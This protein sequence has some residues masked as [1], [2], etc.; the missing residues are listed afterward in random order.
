[1]DEQLTEDNF[2]DLARKAGDALRRPA[3]VD[4]TAR[5]HRTRRR[6]QQTRTATGVA[7]V[8]AIVAIGAAALNRGAG[9]DPA[10]V[11]Q[12][13]VTTE[14]DTTVPT[15][16]PPTT[17][18]GATPVPTTAPDNVTP[19]STDGGPSTTAP[20][21]QVPLSDDARAWVAD[22]LADGYNEVTIQ[23]GEGTTARLLVAL[24]AD[25]DPTPRAAALLDDGTVIGDVE[26]LGTGLD[27]RLYGVGGRPALVQIGSEG[28]ANT[29]TQVWVADPD[30]RAW[31][32]TGDLGL[33]P[34][35]SAGYASLTIRV[36]DD[37]LIVANSQYDDDGNGG[38]L[39]SPDQ[40]GVV[41]GPDL[42]VTEMAPAPDGVTLTFTS[43]WGGRA[44]Q[45]YAP[46][47]EGGIN[48][49]I[50]YD[51]PWQYD[52]VA[53]EWSEIPIPDWADC[54][55]GGCGWVSVADIGAFLLEVPTSRGVVALVPDGTV[56]L[57]DPTA[58][59]WTRLDDPPFVLAMPTVEVVADQVIVGPWRSGIEEFGMIGVL[60]LASGTWTTQQIEIP[61]EIESRFDT[62]WIDVVWHFRVAG[63]RVMATPGSTSAPDLEDPIAVY[64]ADAR[65][66]SEPT[67]ADLTAWEAAAPTVTP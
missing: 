18:P 66:W 21:A 6:R 36:V 34:F 24:R 12:S 37:R 54:G 8:V 52:P 5:I 9:D 13:V 20:L 3:P 53:N 55:P 50:S 51:Q 61:A 15:T 39:I 10:L 29:V 63:S 46:T 22:A 19:P 41:V 42:R 45:L 4:G 16:A 62:G 1:M 7:A 57:Y 32:S 58:R 27:T 25:F 64:D 49:D 28:T 59:T 44:L 35:R 33:Q 14:P 56:G 2:D 11:V 60:D 17:A 48:L 38:L 23:P 65:T 30:T 40:A 67:D 43:A 47:V 26:D 31:V